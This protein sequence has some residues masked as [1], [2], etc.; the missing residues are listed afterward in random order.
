[1]RASTVALLTVGIFT[2]STPTVA[3]HSFAMFDASREIQLRGTVREFRWT[4]PHAFVQIIAA[5]EGLEGEWS[6]EMTS[7][8]HL[9][10]IGWK[11]GTIRP[12]DKITL[13]VH[14]LRNGAHG[15]QFL[16]GF[17]ANG[18][19]LVGESRK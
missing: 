5:N 2:L 4:N 14:P 10:R 7:P 17:D 6:I 1:M 13:V 18:A 15:G 9:W 16:S 8:E 12:G 3:H 19:S 11:P